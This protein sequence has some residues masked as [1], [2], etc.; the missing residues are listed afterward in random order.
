MP[1][2]VKVQ[3]PLAWS[4]GVNP[5]MLAYAKGG[6]K[7]CLLTPTPEV[8]EQIGDRPKAYFNG[9]WTGKTWVLKDV[10]AD[11]PW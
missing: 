10:V 1:E 9:I 6:T 7:K 8:I 4:P 11:Q 2:I 3:V 5:E